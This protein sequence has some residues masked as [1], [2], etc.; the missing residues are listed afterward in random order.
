MGLEVGDE[1]G[2]NGDDAPPGVG[3]RRTEHEGAVA[4]LLILLDDGDTA[5]EQIEVALAQ[6]A[7]L[8]N[9]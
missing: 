1:G 7:E 5:V 4:E 2:R 8:T 3:L 9:A 6:R